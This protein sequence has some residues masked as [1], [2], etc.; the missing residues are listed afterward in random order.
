MQKLKLLIGFT[1]FKP[2]DV[3][4]GGGLDQSIF[5]I[6]TQFTSRVALIETKEIDE[7]VGGVL[8]YKVTLSFFGLS[9][10]VGEYLCSCDGY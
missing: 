1:L 8:C 4:G 9:I 3:N 7:R 5:Q 6:G 10:W 2:H